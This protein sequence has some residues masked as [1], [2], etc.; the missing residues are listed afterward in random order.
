M[1]PM[2]YTMKVG[3]GVIVR[4]NNGEVVDGINKERVAGCAIM[5]EALALKDGVDLAIEKG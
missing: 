4:N 1:V 2:M 5:A 3:I